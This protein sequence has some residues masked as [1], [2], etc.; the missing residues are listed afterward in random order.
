MRL[1]REGPSDASLKLLQPRPRHW[2]AMTELTPPLHAL[3]H[4]QPPWLYRLTLNARNSNS[5]RQQQY[6]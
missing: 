1:F 3:V 4:L 5:Q 2:G 6:L